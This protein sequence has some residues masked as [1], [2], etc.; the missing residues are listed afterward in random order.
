MNEKLNKIIADTHKTMREQRSMR[1]KKIYNINNSTNNNKNVVQYTHVK[2]WGC[3]EKFEKKFLIHI[4]HGKD[5]KRYYCKPCNEK[6]LYRLKHGN[7]SL[8]DTS[9]NI[10]KCLKCGIKD[11]KCNMKNLYYNHYVCKDCY[12]NHKFHDKK[13]SK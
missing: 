10:L 13:K 9:Q 7:Y 5:T 1:D 12:K 6:R 11:K 2:C 8:I 4:F 3:K